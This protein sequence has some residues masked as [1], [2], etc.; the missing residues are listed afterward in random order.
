MVLPALVSMFEI[1]LDSSVAS[2]IRNRKRVPCKP[3]AE[4]YATHTP[5]EGLGPGPAQPTRS[6]GRRAKPT[7]EAVKGRS[8]GGAGRGRP[9]LRADLKHRPERQ[10]DLGQLPVQHPSSLKPGGGG[11]LLQFYERWVSSHLLCR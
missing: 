2:L 4:L 5:R 6:A 7:F 8:S 11:W 1:F 10:S 9:A 3:G